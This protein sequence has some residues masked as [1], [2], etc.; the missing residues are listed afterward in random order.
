[1]DRF[2]WDGGF[3]LLLAGCTLAIAC[4]VPTLKHDKHAPVQRALSRAS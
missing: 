1:V 3:I 2:G 4:I